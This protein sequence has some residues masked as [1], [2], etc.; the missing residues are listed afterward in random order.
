MTISRPLSLASDLWRAGVNMTTNEFRLILLADTYVPN[1]A[2]HSRR[3]SFTAHE[4]ATGGGYTQGGIVV[5]ITETIDSASQTVDFT[6]GGGTLGGSAN[7][8]RYGAWFK[9][10][11]TAANDIFLLLLDFGR[12]QTGPF[13]I[14]AQKIRMFQ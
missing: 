10:T 3:T 11:G 13:V 4:L 1:M 14:P 5:S 8:A 6:F 2:T 9:W 7:Q 12:V